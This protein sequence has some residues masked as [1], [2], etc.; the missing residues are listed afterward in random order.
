[1]KRYAF[2]ALLGFS[3]LL[4]TSCLTTSKKGALVKVYRPNAETASLNCSTAANEGV[5]FMY[6]GPETIKGRVNKWEKKMIA[7]Y[8]RAVLNESRI[9]NSFGIDDAE[10]PNLSIDVLN[11]EVTTKKTQYR[12]SKEG[13]FSVNINIRQAGIIDCATTDPISITK[14]YETA[15]YKSDNL[16]SDQKIKETMIKQ[17]VRRAIRQFVPVKSNVLRPVKTGGDLVDKA[18]LMIDAGNCRGAYEAIVSA[19]NNPNC[20]DAELLYNAGV[21][22]ECMAWNGAYKSNDRTV[23]LQKAKEHYHRAAMMNPGDA[24]MQKASKEVTYEVDIDI[25]ATESGAKIKEEMEELINPPKSY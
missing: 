21:A 9:I 10:Y 3:S 24:D 14:H 18:A 1:M 2:I 12:I 23:Y 19:V 13:T 17:A 15:A 20:K 25:I 7:Q 8:A 22:V 5:H 11:L 4:F 6:V 16:Q